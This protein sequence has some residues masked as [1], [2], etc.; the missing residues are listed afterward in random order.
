MCCLYVSV[1][2][3]MTFATFWD[4]IKFGYDNERLHESI[5]EA[6]YASLVNI[7]HLRKSNHDGREKYKMRVYGSRWESFT[8]NKG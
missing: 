1:F 7:S 4:P 3:Q 8:V 2:I 6:S 5:F